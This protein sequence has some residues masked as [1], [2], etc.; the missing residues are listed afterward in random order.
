MTKHIHKYQRDKLG[1][2]HIIYRCVIPGCTHYVSRKM[3]KNRLSICH[4]CNEPMIIDSFAI[5]LAKPHHNE[6]TKKSTRFN[7]LKDI[8]DDLS[9]IV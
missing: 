4:V 9:S 7:K 3:A 8:I 5:T 1:K 6:C 2:K